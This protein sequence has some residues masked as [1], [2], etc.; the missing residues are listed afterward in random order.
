M[1]NYYILECNRESSGSWDWTKIGQ[2]NQR[3]KKSAG[4]SLNNTFGGLHG[5]IYIDYFDK[6]KRVTVKYYVT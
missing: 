4:V 2:S 3:C 1:K 6:I 5:I